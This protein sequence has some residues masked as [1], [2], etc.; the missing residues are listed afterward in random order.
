LS[1]QRAYGDAVRAATTQLRSDR[2]RND[3]GRRE[4]RQA[5]RVRKIEAVRLGGAIATVSPKD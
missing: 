4:D 3:A 5:Q 2:S 1:S